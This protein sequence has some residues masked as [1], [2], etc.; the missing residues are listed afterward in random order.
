MP[1]LP[2]I[3]GKQETSATLVEIASETKSDDNFGTASGNVL[4]KEDQKGE[5]SRMERSPI[6]FFQK[7]K[8]LGIQLV[9]QNKSNGNM[10]AAPECRC[11]KKGG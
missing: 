2:R 6:L 11:K 8:V 3:S 4:D 10:T 5:P 9:K 7:A 1:R